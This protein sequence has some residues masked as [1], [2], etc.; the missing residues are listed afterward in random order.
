MFITEQL[1]RNEED[2]TY[3]SGQPMEMTME[4]VAPSIHS[5]TA[6]SALFRLLIC[7]IWK[8]KCQIS[9]S[10]SLPPFFGGFLN[11]CL[12]TTPAVGLGL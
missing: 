7:K 5:N 3:K 2:L 10:G 4:W 12:E 6:A 8:L 9:S 11:K 1:P